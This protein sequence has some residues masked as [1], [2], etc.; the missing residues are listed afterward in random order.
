MKLKQVLI[1]IDEAGQFSRDVLGGVALF[2]R[3]HADWI[4]I[5]QYW[6]PKRELPAM[7]LFNG[8]IAEFPREL[9]G[10]TRHR[11]RQLR[12]PLVNVA[13]GALPL[14]KSYRVTVD[15]QLAGQMA[16]EHLAERG[17]R[18]LGFYGF[19]HK[20]YSAQ[21]Q[22]GVMA[23]A[24]RR[25]LAC[26]QDLFVSADLQAELEQLGQW[27]R[28]L[29]K[30]AG[31]VACHDERAHHVLEACAFSGL[32]VPD[33]V[34]V[35]GVGNDRYL[36]EMS[37]PYLSS[38]DLN[39]LQ[40]GQRA[41]ETM[42]ALLS[43]Q[44]PI[45]HEI[46][47]PPGRIIERQSSNTVATADPLVRTAIA[48]IM[49]GL[50]QPLTV[51]AL[52]RGMPYVSRRTLEARFLDAL[53]RSPAEVMRSLRIEKAKTLLTGTTQPISAI[54][55]ACGFSS[56]RWFS[57]MFRRLCGCTPMRYRRQRRHSVP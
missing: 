15:D 55:E 12:I 35:V 54:A 42:Q 27:L 1:L 11:L 20:A 46:L 45:S 49:A 21:I 37:A 32:S 3:R 18:T 8:V 14:R 50:D 33:E 16:V 7:R 28:A 10:P 30:P 29:P 56:Q 34:S 17:F 19:P 4:P 52:L 24:Q 23:E 25:G 36:C 47:I 41:A 51:G 5:L 43:G 9:P 2:T 38:A 53:K 13:R 26:H 57:M 39:G 6:T 22:A 48:Q 44:P 40:V 31:I